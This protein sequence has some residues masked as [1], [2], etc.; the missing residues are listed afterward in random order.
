[1]PL[2][3]FITIDNQ[4]LIRKFW[5]FT[6]DAAV[7]AI[8]TTARGGGGEGELSLNQARP[9][10]RSVAGAAAVASWR[11]R[12]RWSCFCWQ[13]ERAVRYQIGRCPCTDSVYFERDPWEKLFACLCF[14]CC[15]S[16]QH[17]Q[18]ALCRARADTGCVCGALIDFADRNRA[19]LAI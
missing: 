9:R 18:C 15:C 14:L 12:S 3:W 10:A 1:M 19:Y 7:H 17:D 4:V 11:A 13:G 2:L 5:C 8:P 6:R 16:F